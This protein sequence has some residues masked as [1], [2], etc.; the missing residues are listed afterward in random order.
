LDTAKESVA[1]LQQTG[2]LPGQNQSN[3]NDDEKCGR[4]KRKN[5]EL[6]KTGATHVRGSK[7][8]QGLFLSEAGKDQ[9]S[10]RGSRFYCCCVTLGCGARCRSR[11]RLFASWRPITQ[12]A[13]APIAP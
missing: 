2:A 11:S 13:S 10:L 9:L 4:R 8:S 5:Q 12:P 6:I 1:A 3:C 7:Q